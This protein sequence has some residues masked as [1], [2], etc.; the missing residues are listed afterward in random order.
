[1]TPPFFSFGRR[2][3]RSASPADEPK[4]V[5]PVSSAPEP[6]ED[7]EPGPGPGP[8]DDAVPGFDGPPPSE[9]REALV[10][11]ALSA[12]REQL[13]ELGGTASLDDITQLDGVVDLTSAHPSGLAQLYAGRPTHL[14]S[15]VRERGALGVARQC[16][17]KV[18]GRTDQ[19]ARQFGVAPVYLAIGIASWVEVVPASPDSESQEA[20]EA[21]PVAIEPAPDALGGPPA[22]RSGARAGAGPD[23]LRSAASQADDVTVPVPQVPGDGP[24][25]RRRTRTVKAPVLLRPVRLSS[26]SADA[27]LALDPSIEVNPVLTRALRQAGS[28]ADIEAVA[29][30]ALGAEGFTPRTALNRIGTLGREYLSGFLVRENLVVGAFVHPGQALIEDFDA[31]MERARASALVAALAGDPDARAA[32]DVPGAPAGPGRRS[33]RCIRRHRHYPH[34]RQRLFRT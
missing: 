34:R 10:E 9:R 8:A 23:S 6:E 18:A 30:A 26:S 27:T 11:E 21:G 1:M 5:S 12:W 24:E 29:H 15:L 22:P 20:E 28:R 4:D 25:P 19:L 17:R 2:R 16:L 7:D 14:S 13:I 33:P 32:L 31:T 3:R